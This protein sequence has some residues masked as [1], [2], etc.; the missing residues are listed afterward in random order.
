MKYRFQVDFED[1]KTGSEFEKGGN[2]WVKQSTRTARII[3]PVEYS[4]RWFY[5]GKREKINIEGVA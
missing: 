1:V 3:K 5:F 4:S 2:L